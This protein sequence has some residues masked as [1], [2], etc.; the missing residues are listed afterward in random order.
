MP[1]GVNLVTGVPFAIE[2]FVSEYSIAQPE[3]KELVATPLG[4]TKKGK[5]HAKKKAAP[6]GTD[7]ATPTPAPVETK[8]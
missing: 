7:A 8:A 4:P 3:L 2:N 1:N 6:A 5:G